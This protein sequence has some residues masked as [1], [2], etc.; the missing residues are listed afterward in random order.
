MNIELNSTMLLIVLI[1]IIIYYLCVAQKKERMGNFFQQM[2]QQLAQL[3]GNIPVPQGNILFNECGNDEVC[4]E[5]IQGKKCR[6]VLQQWDGNL[7][8][9]DANNKPLW[10]HNTST[11]GS[12]PP[13][14]LKMQ[15]DGNLVLYD[16]KN[17]PIWASNTNGH[18]TG[19]YKATMQDDCN[20]VIYDS[21]GSAIWATNTI[22]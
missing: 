2:D 14:R 19:P 8:I 6:A 22:G 18:G 1:V 7:V 3:R 13:Y 10:G 5:I 17:T 15:G 21:K 20:F 9:Y 12:V 4:R 11:V 16:S